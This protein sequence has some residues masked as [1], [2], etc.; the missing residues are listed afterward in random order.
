MVLITAGPWLK[1]GPQR[2]GEAAGA[3]EQDRGERLRVA[4][5]P[6][7][8]AFGLKPRY[9]R[10]WLCGGRLRAPSAGYLYGAVYAF[11]GPT[12]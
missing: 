7:P 12:R 8:R 1:L 11:A 5:R 6:D 4:T 2:A 10:T 3:E 9:L